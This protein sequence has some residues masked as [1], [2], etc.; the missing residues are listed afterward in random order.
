MAGAGTPGE[1]TGEPSS[2]MAAT[3]QPWGWAWELH[4]VQAR[5]P[6]VTASYQLTVRKDSVILGYL[7]AVPGALAP[8]DAP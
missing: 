7:R 2:S 4:G 8:E 1:A 3:P 6:C 5:D